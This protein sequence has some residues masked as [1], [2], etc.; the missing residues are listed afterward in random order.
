MPDAMGVVSQ[1]AGRKVEF[2]RNSRG[3]I[4]LVLPGIRV[5][6]E[7][8]LLISVFRSGVRSGAGPHR[9]TKQCSEG[10]D[11]EFRMVRAGN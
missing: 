4:T 9:V 1:T 6:V 10:D 5:S 2:F 11:D 8:L 3:S 7:D